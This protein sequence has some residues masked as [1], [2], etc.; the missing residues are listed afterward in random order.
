MF[1]QDPRPDNVVYLRP[2]NDTGTPPRRPLF[3]LPPATKGLCGFLILVYA[4]QVITAPW[5]LSTFAFIPAA[6]IPGAGF[7]FSL[8]LVFAPLVAM[9]LHGGLA[10]LGVNLFMLMALGTATEKRYGGQA[11]LG[12]FFTAGLSGMMLH[13]L[14]FS[15]SPFPVIGASGGVAGLFG[16]IVGR[17]QWQRGG[18]RGVMPLVAIWVIA[19]LLMNIGGL[20]GT[21]GSIAWAVHAGGLL[22]GLFYGLKAAR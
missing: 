15:H 22:A 21:G 7:S 2:A 4:V 11:M 19:D 17:T 18:W 20:P 1:S 8:A 16:L 9:F 6:Y 3:N 14:L 5:L 10:H 13:G 12:V